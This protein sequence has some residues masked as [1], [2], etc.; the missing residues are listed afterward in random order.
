[1][2]D[3]T[4]TEEQQQQQQKRS[5]KKTMVFSRRSHHHD[6]KASPAPPPKVVVTK[7]KQPAAGDVSANSTPLLPSVSEHTTIALA[8]KEKH[9]SAGKKL[10]DWF[11]KKPQSKSF[12][13]FFSLHHDPYCLFCLFQVPKIAT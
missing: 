12:F 8:N 7:E 11:K 2:T 3:Y 13:Y 9:R 10:M 5:T 1:M 6:E 4:G